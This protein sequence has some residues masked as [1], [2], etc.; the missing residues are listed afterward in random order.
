M[1]V[2]GYSSAP[3]TYTYWLAHNKLPAQKESKK[4][5]NANKKDN[6]S[7]TI[8]EVN[9]KGITVSLVT[10]EN[11]GHTWPGSAPFN[12]GYPLGNTTSDIDIN[13]VMWSFFHKNRKR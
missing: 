12:I 11:G 7:V 2:H 13:E 4:V 9:D 8:Q 5:L 1:Q 3:A 6:T 10:V